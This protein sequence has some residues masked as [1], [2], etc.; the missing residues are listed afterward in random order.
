[1]DVKGDRY[2]QEWLKNRGP[3]P[4]IDGFKEPSLDLQ[5]RAILDVMVKEDFL[6]HVERTYTPLAS[7]REALWRRLFEENKPRAV[8]EHKRRDRVA[9]ARCRLT[10]FTLKAHALALDRRRREC[11]PLR[12][13]LGSL[14]R[15]IS[16]RR[17]AVAT[18]PV[19]ELA[20]VPATA[21]FQ[22]RVLPHDAGGAWD[23]PREPDMPAYDKS[24]LDSH[25]VVGLTGAISAFVRIWWGRAAA[26]ALLVLMAQLF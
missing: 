12:G 15:E 24:I 9:W 14:K 21:R 18:P 1:M 3:G 10:T 7:D 5:L 26:I 11:G 4:W 25:P 8:E 23:L 19:R 22:S 17:A 13:I 20:A 16:R 2:K 6:S